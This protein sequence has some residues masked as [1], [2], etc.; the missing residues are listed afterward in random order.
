MNIWKLF[1]TRERFDTLKCALEKEKVSV[2]ELARELNLSKGF[3]S[4]F[5]RILEGEGLL[6]REGRKYVVK[7]TAITRTLKVFINT[8]TIHEILMKHKKDWMESLGFYG[9]F[10]SGK[11]KED[12]DVDVW[13]KVSKHPGE[14][15]IARIEREL[16]DELG[17]RVHIIV[18]TP[19]R[20]GRLKK[21]DFVF[22][23]ELKRSVVIWGEGIE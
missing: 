17:K 6:R 9:S 3:V 22:Y 19:E 20:L 2:E 1:A 13:I 14:K 4:Q 16:S 11:N 15:E 10:A 23:C 5:L 7:D 21:D 12:S 8:A 18:L